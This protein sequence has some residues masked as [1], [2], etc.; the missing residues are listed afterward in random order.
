M[1]ILRIFVQQ[2]PSVTHNL[3]PLI[4]I[5]TM[6][7]LLDLGFRPCGRSV[8]WK[9]FA[10]NTIVS[11]LI[12][13]YCAVDFERSLY[14]YGQQ[15]KAT[16]GRKINFNGMR[17]KI[18]LLRFSFFSPFARMRFPTG[19]RTPGEF[20]VLS[21]VGCFIFQLAAHTVWEHSH[22]TLPGSRSQPLALPDCISA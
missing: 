21:N 10:K 13:F 22:P 14:F 17:T 15:G 5:P 2:L 18:A 8:C 16:T 19:Q 1:M 3:N 20:K 4:R 7:S 9:H 6:K 12:R 11:V